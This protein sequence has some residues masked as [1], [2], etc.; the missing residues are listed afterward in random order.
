MNTYSIYLHVTEDSS[1]CARKT[2]YLFIITKI[3]RLKYHGNGEIFDEI[4]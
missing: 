1:L 4:I 2:S 3:L